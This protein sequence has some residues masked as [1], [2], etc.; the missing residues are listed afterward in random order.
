MHLGIKSPLNSGI[1][2]APVTGV[3]NPSLRGMQSSGPSF[4]VIVTSIGLSTEGMVQFKG[5]QEAIPECPRRFEAPTRKD[6][7]RHERTLRGDQY[8]CLVLWNSVLARRAGQLD[9]TYYGR[10]SSWSSFKSCSGGFSGRVAEPA[11]KPAAIDLRTAHKKP[12]AEVGT[13]GK[14]GARIEGK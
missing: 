8:D 5:R 9:E 7:N 12:T 1:R 4:I 14:E 2:C 10:S 6:C 3:E 11:A 13:S